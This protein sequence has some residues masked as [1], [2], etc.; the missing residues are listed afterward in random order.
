MDDQFTGFSLE[1]EYECLSDIY[2]QA[3]VNK[4]YNNYPK[5]VLVCFIRHGLTTMQDVKTIIEK[6]RA[7]S[8]RN[9]G[10]RRKMLAMELIKKYEDEAI[11]K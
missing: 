11:I 9:L 7:H 1:Q 4:G 5:A 3:E 6:K 8:I 10:P 2:L